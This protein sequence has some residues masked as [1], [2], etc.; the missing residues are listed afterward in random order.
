MTSENKSKETVELIGKTDDANSKGRISRSERIAKEKQ[1]LLD[2]LAANN[3]KDIRSKVAYVLN[4]YPPSRNSDIILAFK[5]WKTFEPENLPDNGKLDIDTMY[6]IERYNSISRARAKIQNEYGLFQADE[7]VKSMRRKKEIKQKEKEIAD[8]PGIPTLLF[9]LDESGKNQKFIIV[10]G[11]CCTNAQ[12]NFIIHNALLKWKEDKHINYEFHFTEM[13]RTKLDNYKA[14][15]AE[16]LSHFDTISFKAVAVAKDDLK[17]RPVDEVICELHY[18]LTHTGTEHEVKTGR[19]VL[20]R[21][22][23]IYKDK[24]DGI[25]AIYLTKLEQELKSGFTKHFK[26]NLQL[27][28]LA[29]VPSKDNIYIQIADLFIGSISRILNS[30]DDAGKNHKDEFAEFVVSTL[31]LDLE[32]NT[33]S[34]QDIAYINILGY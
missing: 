25:D 19:I 2:K 29:A 10:G 30:V 7:K 27:K 9:Y 4:I 21:M 14:F 31:G 12:R 5:Y 17:G 16:A 24:D 28:I 22:V 3:L 6:K 1:L 26:D 34:K 11:L 33:S 18:Q 32:N 15:F 8:K 23:H 13:S 20:P